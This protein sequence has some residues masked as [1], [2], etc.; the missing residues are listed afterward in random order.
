M[1]IGGEWETNVIWMTRG[2]WIQYARKYNALCFQLEHRFYGQS[3]PTEDL[4]IQNLK[5]L[6][7][8]QALADL[9]NF[10]VAMNEKHQL[11]I[12]TVKWIAFGGSY[13]GSLA[14]WLRVKYPHRVFGAV[15]SSG[16]LLAKA[17]F[18]EFY[19]E[20]SHALGS[21][22]ETCVHAVQQSFGQVEAQLKNEAGRRRLHEHF[23]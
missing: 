15:S 12:D 11:D 7:S 21:Y 1:M 17:D 18:P 19:E 8:E 9:A 3:H 4:S 14:A 10:I 13:A 23:Q 6:S 2:N 22:S 16:P 5:Y 20:V